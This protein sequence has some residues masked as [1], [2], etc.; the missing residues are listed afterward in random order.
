MKEYLKFVDSE[1]AEIVRNAI[2]KL[3]K[4][5]DKEYLDIRNYPAL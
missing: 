5:T 2:D 3:C 1:M 4:A